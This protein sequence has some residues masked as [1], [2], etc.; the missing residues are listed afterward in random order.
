MNTRAIYTFSVGVAAILSILQ[1]FLGWISLEVRVPIL[2]SLGSAERYG[3]DGDG[4]IVLLVGL[5]ALGFAAYLWID[6]SGKAFRLVTIFN[7]CLGALIVATALVNLLDSQR[8]LGD[9]QQQVGID[10]D[11]L[12][13][14][15]LGNATSAEAGIYVAIASGAL[16]AAASIGAWVASGTKR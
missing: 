10:L 2:G 5:L 16:L 8:A 15:D 11:A 4:V 9:A 12:V 7:A 14:I 13:G 6:R 1:L 3:Y